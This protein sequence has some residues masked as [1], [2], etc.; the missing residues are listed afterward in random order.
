M[1][2][3]GTKIILTAERT[4]WE[5]LQTARWMKGLNF[6]RSAIQ[7]EEGSKSN[8]QDYWSNGTFSVWCPLSIWNNDYKTEKVLVVLISLIRVTP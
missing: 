7:D 4:Y 6:S 3:Q 2:Q 8:L 1:N 5:E